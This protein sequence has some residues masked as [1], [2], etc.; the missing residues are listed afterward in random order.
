MIDNPKYASSGE[1]YNVWRNDVVS[2]GFGSKLNVD[3][4]NEKED[5]F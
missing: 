3:F 1:A 2:L 4:P 5:L